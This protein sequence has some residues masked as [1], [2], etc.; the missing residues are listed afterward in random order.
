MRYAVAHVRP[1]TQ[2]QTPHGWV[3]GNPV[4]GGAPLT[5]EQRDYFIA[6]GYELIELPDVLPPDPPPTE[7]ELAQQAEAERERERNERDTARAAT[8]VLAPLRKRTHVKK[9]DD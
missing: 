1:G 9:G 2:I 8:E 5:K 4:D 3:R 6:G 7:D